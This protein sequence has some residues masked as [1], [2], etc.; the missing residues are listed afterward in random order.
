MATVEQ[1]NAVRFIETLDLAETPAGLP[2]RTGARELAPA[3]DRPG[4]YV[5]AGSIPSFVEDVSGLHRADVLNSTLLAQLAANAQHDREKRP[6]EWYAFY[7]TVL[8]QVGWTVSRWGFERYEAGGSSLEVEKV[9]LEILAAV[10]TSNEVAVATAALDALRR[11]GEGDRPFKVWDV[12]T[13]TG[14]AAN[15]QVFAVRERND[16]VSMSIGAFHFRAVDV[17]AQFLWVSYASSTIEL[18]KGAQAATLNEDAYA[19]VRETVIRKL[20]DNAAR[21][22]AELPIKAPGA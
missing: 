1:E 15:F 6:V 7:R 22:V 16:V 21:F 4:A 5:D 12:S 10:A 17:T 11:L 14:K 20:G 19:R 9:V 2:A 3:E 13:H 18:Y 8:E